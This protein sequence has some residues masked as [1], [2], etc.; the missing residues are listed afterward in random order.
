MNDP[1]RDGEFVVLPRRETGYCSSTVQDRSRT[2]SQLNCAS[3]LGRPRNLPI[4]SAGCCSLK[5]RSPPRTFCESGKLARSHQISR[6]HFGEEGKS[7]QRTPVQMDRSRRKFR[8][9]RGWKTRAG[10]AART[11]FA[12]MPGRH[13]GA[14]NAPALRPQAI[15]KRLSPVWRAVRLCWT[16]RNCQDRRHRRRLLRGTCPPVRKM[17]NLPRKRL[18]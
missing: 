2:S 11:A 1:Q 18:R 13:L 6:R 3:F 7:P 16:G 17:S 9:P 5:I 14:A 15:R 12:T 8:R 10:A 4:R